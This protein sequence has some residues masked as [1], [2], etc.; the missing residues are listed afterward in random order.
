[1]KQKQY[2]DWL[3]QEDLQTPGLSLFA[4]KKFQKAEKGLV[5]HDHGSCMEI[6]FLIR[7]RQDYYIEDSAYSLI[8][9]QAFISFPNQPHK[10]AGPFQDVG[11][12]YW[13]Q[14]DLSC[15]DNFLGLGKELSRQ[16]LE[17]LSQINQHIVPF[18]ASVKNL[19]QPTYNEF[20]QNGPTPLARCAF[21]HLLQL[22]LACTQKKL[23]TRDSF[24][25]LDQYIEE[26]VFEKITMEQ[27]C[28]EAN[29]SLSTLQHSF[30]TYFGR[31]PA[32]YI[33]YRKIQRS[34][35]LLLAGKNIT[36][37][38][39]C[40]G[41]GSSDYYSTVFRKFNG[42]SPSVWIQNERTAE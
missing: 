12:I 15:R 24:Q 40:M 22:F 27:L 31:S 39:M 42:T 13:C 3:Q 33:N 1:M 17:Q 6:V 34:K 2:F 38:A 29:I 18:D 9:G 14:L 30:K 8:G 35:E 28:Q 10:S 16:T 4:H 11:E 19:L 7:G 23:S 20:C 37:T 25:K 32:E 41:F 26:H 21:M 36:E 5:M